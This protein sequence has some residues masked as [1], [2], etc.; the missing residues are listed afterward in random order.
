M[1]SWIIFNLLHTIIVLGT[2]YSMICRRVLHYEAGNQGICLNFLPGVVLLAG[3]SKER[4]IERRL[5]L[6]PSL[7]YFIDK[8][9]QRDEKR[10]RSALGSM[11]RE[12]SRSQD[13]IAPQDKFSGASRQV[14]V[15]LVCI[16]SYQGIRCVISRPTAMVY[17]NAMH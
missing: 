7:M 9:T 2:R 3:H 5:S 1:L 15:F 8:G 16:L 17:P 12:Y 14:L 13:C 11:Q 10:T 4:D 6:R